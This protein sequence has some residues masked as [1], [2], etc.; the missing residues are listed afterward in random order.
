MTCLEDCYML[1]LETK[2]NFETI[3]EIKDQGYSRIPVFREERTEIV[4]ILFAKDLLFIDPDDE[5]NRIWTL[6]PHHSEKDLITL[7]LQECLET[8]RRMF[9]LVTLQ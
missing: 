8:E 9:D 3:S 6:P 5:V 7:I 2:L 4:H 1:P